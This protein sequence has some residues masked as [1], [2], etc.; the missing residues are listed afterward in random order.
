MGFLRVEESKSN[1]V[2]GIAL[3]LGVLILC[4][5]FTAL[6]GSTAGEIAIALASLLAGMLALLAGILA[7]WVGQ[8]QVDW[9]QTSERRHLARETLI[10]TRLIDSVLVRVHDDVA[11]LQNTLA[12]PQYQRQGATA[13][14]DYS[15]LVRKP[16]VSVVWDRLGLCNPEIVR[17]YMDLD[18]D[19]E[20][21]WERQIYGAQYH[22]DTLTKIDN[23]I[24]FL[25]DELGNEAQKCEDVLSST[26]RA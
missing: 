21:Y 3:A 23:K 22:R 15:R 2:L 25:R 4:G 20:V 5:L 11:K 26:Q 1:L 17:T 14:A 24:E 16:N 8:R 13:P 6:A 12:Q 9:L 7:Y 18:A 19:I 10:A